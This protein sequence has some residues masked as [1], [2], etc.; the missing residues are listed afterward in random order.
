MK[1]L[2]RRAGVDLEEGEADVMDV[3]EISEDHSRKRLNSG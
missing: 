1:G 2:K 3:D